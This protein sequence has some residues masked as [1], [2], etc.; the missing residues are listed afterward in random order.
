[1]EYYQ[2]QASQ[3][4]QTATSN[5]ATV[6]SATPDPT[7][8]SAQ[9]EA[10][11]GHHGGLEVVTPPHGLYYTNGQVY[12]PPHGPTKP[13]PTILG[14][15]RTTFILSVILIFVIIVAAVGGGVGGS[16]AVKSAETN[17]LA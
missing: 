5:T 15:R 7:Q 16:M 13:E 8:Y 2:P 12:Y 4:P 17:C 1:M 3:T 14:V 10:Y 9:K 6:H 11:Q